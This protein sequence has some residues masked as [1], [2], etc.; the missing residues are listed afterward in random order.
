[1]VCFAFTLC[2]LTVLVQ[3]K[4]TSHLVSTLAVEEKS[5]GWSMGEVVDWPKVQEELVSSM[6]TLNIST[7]EGESPSELRTALEELGSED[8]C[9]MKGFL[10]DLINE[11]ESIGPSYEDW[12]FKKLP[13]KTCIESAKDIFL[14]G[15]E[16]L[17]ALAVPYQKV[18]DNY[19][20]ELKPPIPLNELKM[21]QSLWFLRNWFVS[22][23]SAKSSALLWA[24]VWDGDASNRTTKRKLFEFAEDVDHQT[25]HPDTKLG[26][27][28]FKHRD[29]SN[30]Y[31]D[32]TVSK[33]TNNMWSFASMAFMLGM[34][35]NEQ[36]TVVA[37]LNK[38]IDGERPL[39]DS[40]LFQH[41]VPTVGVAAW[42]T[43][44]LWSPQFLLID[45]KGTC[46]KTSQLLRN[47]LFTRLSS[48]KPTRE[49]LWREFPRSRNLHGLALTA[50]QGSV[51]WTRIWPTMC[52]R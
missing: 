47:Q 32:P 46:H 17:K 16:L 39:K 19:F 38:D 3:G 21:I 25:V 2:C 13:K 42:G 49:S 30:C 15:E 8:A 27:L 37:L 9:E 31:K 1:M 20:G 10:K 45:M 5:D 35:K 14:H 34:Q 44:A 51:I 52:R 50:I 4:R 22:L 29:L 24:G 11:C 40:I 36:S 28:I 12:P 43:D 23:A 18:S 7:I 48:F 33:L 26:Q 6:K 41:E